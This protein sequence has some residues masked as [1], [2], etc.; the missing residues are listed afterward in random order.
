[1]RKVLG[2]FS[3]NFIR[4][5]T[6]AN[7]RISCILGLILL[8]MVAWQPFSISV[9]MYWTVWT[10][11]C[12]QHVVALTSLKIRYFHWHSPGGTVALEC[13]IPFICWLSR[14][15]WP[16]DYLCCENTHLAVLCACYS[17]QVQSNCSRKWIR[18]ARIVTNIQ[19][20]IGHLLSTEANV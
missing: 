11:Q 7:G 15:M 14:D 5:W 12:Q 10:I 1:M 20:V 3:P 2:W 19:P 17:S 4:L 18:S 13:C 9:T 8:T 16:A 6:T